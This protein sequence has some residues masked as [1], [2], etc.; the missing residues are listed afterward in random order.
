MAVLVGE[1][2]PIIKLNFEP[3]GR[4]TLEL[5]DLKIDREEYMCHNRVNQ[6]VICGQQETLSRYHVVPGLYRQHF[7]EKLKNHRAFDVLL[8]CFRCRE[9]ANAE[10][11]KFKLELTKRFDVPLIEFNKP[12]QIKLAA[13]AIQKV[14][15]TFTKFQESMPKDRKKKIKEDIRKNFAIIN[16]DPTL[17]PEIQKELDKFDY[18]ENGEVKINEKFNEFFGNVKNFKGLAQKNSNK[19]FRNMHGRLVVE[20]FKSI[21]EIKAFIDEWRAYFISTM[22]PMFLPH[23]WNLA[24]REKAKLKR[25]EISE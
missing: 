11:D 6:C 17:H 4:G 15:S 8:M 14:L 20:K 10:A 12:Q 1:D 22:N 5:S 7:P 3:S 16:L 13:E 2:P 23:D 19:D 21:E 25:K 18:K 24:L 9:K